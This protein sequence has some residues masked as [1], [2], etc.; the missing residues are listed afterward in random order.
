MKQIIKY[1]AI[2][3]IIMSILINKNVFINI[4]SNINLLTK[5]I[6][7]I[8][9]IELNYLKTKNKELNDNLEQLSNLKS[10]E[11]NYKITKLSYFDNHEK[12]HFY[13]NTSH[14]KN[15]LLINEHGLVGIVSKQYNDYSKC[16]PLTKLKNIS[17]NINDT[18]GTL[19]HYKDNTFI[20]E[21]ISN[22]EEVS[23]SDEVYTV[24]TEQ[25]KDKV[26]IGFVDKI[27]KEDINKVIFI[28]SKV[29]FNNI[30][31]LYVVGT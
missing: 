30:T 29:D 1:S 24:P 17:V 12:N 20:I 8:Y 28:K 13:I 7:N 18:Y 6:S 14:N 5:P 31:Y 22:Y 4:I 9:K 25:Y 16:T 23:L 3:I 27:I 21:D 2:I 11:L 10:L 19:N 15:S 26:L